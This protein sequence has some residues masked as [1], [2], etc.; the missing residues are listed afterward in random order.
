VQELD[1]LGED[2]LQ[3]LVSTALAEHVPRGA[4]VVLV[5]VVFGFDD[6]TV[7]DSLGGVPAVAFPGCG[8]LGVDGEGNLDAGMAVLAEVGGEV[9]GRGSDA[10]PALQTVPFQ[11][12]PA[13]PTL[14]HR[15]TNSS[16]VFRPV[17]PKATQADYSF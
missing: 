10:P 4:L 12:N 8:N 14:T 13:N 1:P 16:F 17:A 15:C 2:V 6:L 11:T 7:F 3:F 5:A 9:P